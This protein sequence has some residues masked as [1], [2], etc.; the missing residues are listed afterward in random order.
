MTIRR[1]GLVATLFG[2]GAA[3]AV[4]AQEDYGKTLCLNCGEYYGP[5]N[6]HEACMGKIRQLSKAKRNDP[7]DYFLV[8]T[9]PGRPSPR[10]LEY[11]LRAFRDHPLF[12]AYGEPL[13]LD[14]GM[15]IPGMEEITAVI[16][17][18][19]RLSNA[20][21]QRLQEA[22]EKS[23]GGNGSKVFILEEGMQLWKVRRGTAA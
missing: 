2:L 3:G 19:G 21:Y 5:N 22:W 8:I 23:V 13:I 9:H 10:M 15:S 11:L 16:H 14:E 4:E 6:N 17:H 1:R 7:A 12:A 18:P 20:G